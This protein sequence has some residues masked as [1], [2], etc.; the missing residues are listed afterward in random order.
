M[1]RSWSGLEDIEGRLRPATRGA[2]VRKEGRSVWV[3]SERSLREYIHVVVRT[4]STGALV[5]KDRNE[6]SINNELHLKS[7][8]KGFRTGSA[9]Y[10]LGDMGVSV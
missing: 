5:V 9:F 1:P 10:T 8:N 2:N 4:L 3:W 7:G 6:G